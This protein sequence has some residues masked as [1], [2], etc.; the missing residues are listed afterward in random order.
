MMIQACTLD[1]PG[2]SNTITPLTLQADQ[3]LSLTEL[4]WN[5]VKVTGFREYIILQSTNEIPATPTPEVS[6]NVTILKRIDDA[7]VTSFST[8]NIL[9]T[10]DVCYKLYVSIEDRF[11]QSPNICVH[12]DFQLFNGFYDRAAHEDGIDEMV[13]FDRVNQR[14]S[15]YNYKEGTITRSVNE[16]FLSFPIL[17]LSQWEDNI[18]LF[19]YDQSPGVLRKYRYPELTSSMSKDFGG[20]LFAAN[21]HEQFIVAAIEDFNGSLKVLSRSNLSVLDSK[22]GLLGNRNVAVF[23]GDPLIT[24]DIS[25]N[26]ILRYNIDGSGKLAL[27]DTK[28][29]GISQPSSQNAAAQGTDLFISGRLG[30]IVD[31]DGNIAGTL[32]SNPNETVW[33]ARFSEDER[34]VVYGL[35]AGINLRLEIADISNLGNITRLSTFNIPSANYSDMVVED[36]I[37]YLTGVTF[38]SG[39]AQTF[40]LKYPMP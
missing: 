37:I 15:S 19:A 27:I 7:D 13:M 34:K 11:I 39:Q 31:R 12:Q 20:V 4:H 29:H 28:A 33:M 10:P 21:F 17:E 8:S 24:L 9:F 36:G 2:S 38:D 23:E 6:A 26:E 35:N 1:D 3:N 40:T 30:T 32:N 18:S 22:Q 16:I 14:L 5:A 25:D